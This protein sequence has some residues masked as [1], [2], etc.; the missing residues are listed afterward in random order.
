MF[1]KVD[2]PTLGIIENMSYFECPECGTRS[3]IFGHGGA[4]N[5][6]ERLKVPFLG[7]IPLH[8]TI[9]ASSDAGTPVMESDPQG[10]HAAIYRAIGSQIK[11]QIERVPAKV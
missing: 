11:E 5:E 1:A 8:M 10:T 4:R 7:E 2:V 6:A 3:D 9:R